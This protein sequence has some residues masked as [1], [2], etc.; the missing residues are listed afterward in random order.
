MGNGESE[1]SVYCVGSRRSGLA[2]Y[3]NGE[4]MIPMGLIH[5]IRKPQQILATKRY[6]DTDQTLF[7]PTSLERIVP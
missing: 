4:R 7:N 6:R 3:L 2:R 5:R 1:D